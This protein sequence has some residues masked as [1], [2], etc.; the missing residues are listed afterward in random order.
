MPNTPTIVTMEVFPIAGRDCMEL[1]L[2]GAHA[3]YF[4]R[5]VVVLTD[6]DGRT[7][8]GEVPGGQKI[9][10]ALED[11]R[12]LVLGT[13]IGNYKNTLKRINDW[14]SANIKDDVR[15]QQTFDL[16]TG[17]HVVTAVEAP[18][19]DLLGQYLNFAALLGDGIQREKVYSWLPFYLGDPKKTDLPHHTDPD[20]EFLVSP[21]PPGGIDCRFH[22]CPCPC[23]IR[24][25][26]LSRL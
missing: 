9:T 10:K 25:V 4:T 11:V 5:N 6:S 7:G 16:R 1:N 24:K 2:S 3:P 12:H 8:I 13:D 26:R 14:L 19:L 18:M 20:N 22:R 17:V 15:G 21:A 23:R